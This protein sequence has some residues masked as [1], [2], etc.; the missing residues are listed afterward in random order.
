[1]TFSP[2]HNPLHTQQVP[3]AATSSPRRVTMLFALQWR[4]SDPILDER[5][6]DFSMS[7]GQFLSP[8]QISGY[9][10]SSISA[11]IV[12]E[13]VQQNPQTIPAVLG[14]TLK[15]N[16]IFKATFAASWEAETDIPGFSD[17]IVRASSV[18]LARKIGQSVLAG[19]GGTDING[20]TN[21]I[22]CSIC[23]EPNTWKNYTDR[24]FEYLFFCEQI[25]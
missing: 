24:Y 10:L 25:L 16:I 7:P 9:N 17:K 13:T 6:T 11:S 3:L 5:V 2:E 15:N 22:W 4:K 20:I 12:G 19:R 18:A 1:M 14:A 23:G 21:G 8:E